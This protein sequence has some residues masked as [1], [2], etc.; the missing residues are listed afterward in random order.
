MEVMHSEQCPTADFSSWRW[1]SPRTR[2]WVWIGDV[3]IYTSSAFTLQHS[4]ASSQFILALLGSL[5][6]HLAKQP[7]EGS[8][9]DNVDT[10]Q[11]EA[12]ADDCL[13]PI[14]C[15]ASDEVFA[16]LL[17]VGPMTCPWAAATMERGTRTQPQHMEQP[18]KHGS[19]KRV[20]KEEAFRW[21]EGRENSPR[22]CHLCLLF[23]I[24]QQATGSISSISELISLAFIAIWLI[25]NCRLT[26]YV[27]WRNRN[28]RSVA[29][30]ALYSQI[31]IRSI[32]KKA[33]VTHLFTEPAVHNALQPYLRGS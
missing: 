15:E 27:D 14:G 1:P 6:G 33:R 31:F 2:A 26:F 17:T 9:W 10:Q 5:S 32:W 25:I 24:R 13:P 20:H 21:Q 28:L 23:N 7:G 16:S 29:T 22:Q 30:W 8:S 12:I 4:V 3:Y 18:L 11:M 19:N